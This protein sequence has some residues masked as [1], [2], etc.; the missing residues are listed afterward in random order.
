MHLT[1]EHYA[2]LML[3][4]PLWVGAVLAMSPFVLIGL[5]IWWKYERQ[6]KI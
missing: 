1:D 6:P 5:W 4:S 3:T 2:W